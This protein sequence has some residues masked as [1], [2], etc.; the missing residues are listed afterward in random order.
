MDAELASTWSLMAN[1]TLLHWTFLAIAL[2]V[3]VGS[4]SLSI[5]EREQVIVPLVGFPLPGT[6]MF[7]EMTGLPCPGCGLTRSFI[8]I[9]HGRLLDAWHYNPA[10]FVLFAV[11]VFQVPY[12]AF[13][14]LR[15]RRGYG[16]HRFAWIDNGVLILLVVALVVQ[17]IYALANGLK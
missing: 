6:C 10:G 3:V 7:R 15:I 13:Q 11:I 17:W 12:R 8:S 1:D 14:I 16:Q 9:G 5:R 4:F 2:V